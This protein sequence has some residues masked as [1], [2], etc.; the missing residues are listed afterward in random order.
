MEKKF[1]NKKHNNNKQNGKQ[2]PKYVP[3]YSQEVLNEPIS[4]L[5]I[6]NATYEILVSANISHLKDLLI[7]S[8]KDLFKIHYFNKKH[9]YNLLSALKQKNLALKPQDFGVTKQVQ[10]TQKPKQEKQND[11]IR[12]SLQEFKSTAMERPPKPNK[13]SAINPPADIYIKISK[14]GLFGFK[15]KRSNRIVIE[16]IFEEVFSFKEDLC[17]FQ[18]DNKFGFFD[19]KGTI[20]IEPEYD[21]AFSFS[22]GYACVYKND[23]CGY[24]DKENNT[25]IDFIYDAGTKVI[26]GECR[27]KKGSQWGELHIESP[28]DVRWIV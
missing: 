2:V 13:V 22:D 28:N 8:E 27:V 12:D 6:N 14:N 5:K 24:I 9:L 7:K 23:K 4:I 1:K 20:I 21:I 3:P 16:P 26:D 10:E 18:K 19:R 11:F 15:D 17:C 25:I